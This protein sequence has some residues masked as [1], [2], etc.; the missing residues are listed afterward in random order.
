MKENIFFTDTHEIGQTQKPI[1]PMQQMGKGAKVDEIKDIKDIASALR[2]YVKKKYPK[3]KFSA[4]I[5]RFAGGQALRVNWYQ[6]DFNPLVSEEAW[7]DTKEGK[8]ITI[9]EN[10]IESNEKLTPKAKSVLQDVVDFYEQYNYDFSEPQSDYYNVRFYTSVYVGTWGKPFEQVSGKPEKPRP[11]KPTGG[12]E[13]GIEPPM[14]SDGQS[15]I[16]KTSQ[17]DKEGTI[18]YSKYVKSQNKYIYGIRTSTNALL[19]IW[20]SNIRALNTPQETPPSETPTEFTPDILEMLRVLEDGVPNS[21]VGS[22]PLLQDKDGDYWYIRSVSE[23]KAEISKA[24]D[25]GE[26]IDL[27][28]ANLNI[29]DD[30][31]ILRYLPN[32]SKKLK[33]IVVEWSETGEFDEGETFYTWNDFQAKT[34]TIDVSGGGYQKTKLFI[35]WEN[36]RALIDRV[37][38]GN[39]EGDF[40]PN[41]DFIGDYIGN[42]TGAMYWSNFT[43]GERKNEALWKD[44]EEMPELPFK[45]GD[46]F[47]ANQEGSIE[48]TYTITK[49]D[50]IKT[51]F[52]V[53]DLKTGERIMSSFTTIYI[54]N[55]ISNRSWIPYDPLDENPQQQPETKYKVGDVF[56]RNLEGEE[57]PNTKITYT[58]LSI[59]EEKTQYRI[60]YLDKQSNR[61]STKSNEKILEEITSDW[62]VKYELLETPLETKNE[63]IEE[64]DD[65][66]IL[67]NDLRKK[68]GILQDPDAQK[69]FR[70]EISSLIDTREIFTEAEKFD[71]ENLISTYFDNAIMNFNL[72]ITSEQLMVDEN[73]IIEITK[74]KDFKDWFGD[75]ENTKYPSSK[76]IKINTETFQA[77]PMVVYHGTKNPTHYSRFKNDKFPLIYFAT[78]KKYAEWFAQLGNGIIYECFLNVRFPINFMDLGLNDITWQEL[79]EFVK[80]KYGLEL[81]KFPNLTERRKVWAWIRFDAETNFSLIN[82]IKEAEFDAIIH[83]ENNPQQVDDKGNEEITKA[84][85]IFDPKNVKLVK[86]AKQTKGFSEIMFLKEG[87]RLSLMEE[88]KNLKK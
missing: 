29:L 88:I 60:D 53:Q 42:Q 64:L 22:I 51:E 67:L 75:W 19:T 10:Y 43:S 48:A 7:G 66:L 61:L 65:E 25:V 52:R 46:V 18:E 17:G 37:D 87:G 58:I 13:Q 50:D 34:K 9:N 39:S 82:A 5:E 40:D 38:F 1:K 21:E 74:S 24:T 23:K 62:W 80:E 4:N 72:P 55:I 31:K 81:P 12:T 2:Q 79:S 57:P 76:A 8:R 49:I 33:K 84:Y 36:N 69:E 83:I 16:Y 6:A 59:G 86:F 20:E 3:Y 56:R 35:L 78:N 54:S 71:V 15:V 47:R 77:T 68:T 28:P 14:F 45:V 73:E 32:A 27:T 63:A 44:T 26:R 85:M 41:R 70:E 11:S 30:F